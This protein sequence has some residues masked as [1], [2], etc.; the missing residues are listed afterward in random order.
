[1]ARRR[2]QLGAL[3]SPGRLCPLRHD[4]GG[5]VVVC[6]H[7]LRGL[8]KKGDQCRFL[9]QYDSARMPACYFYS[10]L[11]KRPS[12]APALLPGGRPRE[13]PFPHPHPQ[14]RPRESQG[15]DRARPSS[16]AGPLQR[17]GESGAGPGPAPGPRTR[18]QP[19]SGTHCLP[20]RVRLESKA[21]LFLSPVLAN[22]T[23]TGRLERSPKRA[24][25]Q[26]WGWGRGGRGRRFRNSRHA[27]ASSAVLA[28]LTKPP[29]P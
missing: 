11:G 1:M 15:A 23:Q 28:V 4:H 14:R 5:K 13:G 24:T 19:S 8:C 25:S 17:P 27:G 26:S 29:G 21:E 22:H 6:K 2:P 18:S 12:R 3:V 7:W 9:H 10:K 20:S 16:D